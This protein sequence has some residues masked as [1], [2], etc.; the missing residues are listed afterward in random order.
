MR[1]YT[2]LHRWPNAYIP[3]LAFGIMSY[4]LAFFS[5]DNTYSLIGFLACGVF[6]LLIAWLLFRSRGHYLDIGAEWIDHQGFTRWRIRKSEVLR[7]E[8][9]RKGLIE[10]Y[11]PYLKLYAHGREYVVDSGFLVD[12]RRIEQLVEALR[13]GT[14]A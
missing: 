11:D 5:A 10:E 9:G 4:A 1:Y 13:E 7:V 14:R 12:E 8:R 3:A 6:A 2:Q